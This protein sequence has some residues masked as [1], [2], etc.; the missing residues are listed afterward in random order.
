MKKKL[1]ALMCGLMCATAFT[2]CSNTELAY[3]KM[4]NDMVNTMSTCQVEGKMQADLD[5]DAAQVLLND[6]AKATGGTAFTETALSG[7]KSMMVT[8]D[9]HINM[10]AMAYDM[11]F[12][13]D[14]AGKT[15][16]LGTLY[17][18]I[19]DGIYVTSDTI[20]G[21]YR[22]A[23]A[24][25]N[26]YENR[27][28]MSDAFAKDFKTILAEDEYIELLSLEDLTGTDMDNVLPEGSMT[29]LYD[30]VFTFYQDV[31]DGFETGMVKEANGGYEIKADG[32]EVAQLM[33][34]LLHFIAE[35][36]EQVMDATEAYMMAVLGG[37]EMGNAEETAEAQE[38]MA[39][40][41]AEMRAS[42]GEFV[43]AVEQA[44]VVLEQMLTEEP[45]GMLLDT[46]TYEAF[47]KKTGAGFDSKEVYDVTYQDKTVFRLKTDGKLTK[48]NV[49][50]TMPQDSISVDKLQEELIALEDK[51]NPVTGVS[52]MWGW[53][54][55]NKEATLYAVRAEEPIFGGGAEWTDLVIQ[56]G[57]AY[58]PL[59]VVA[60]TLG[61]KVG[62]ENATKTP[63]VWMDG[64][65]VEMK[66]ILQDNRAFV[67]VRDFEKLG[68][69]VTFTNHGDGNKE[70]LVA[71]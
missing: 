37:M 28:V 26:G 4:C 10:D 21:M 20:W 14:Y 41:F 12:D 44:A 62:W 5:F 68:Y 33:V 15:Y 61:E 19:S 1:A 18:G 27:Y 60:E 52:M 53:E 34:N 39:A 63:Y 7:Q 42:Q 56:N 40:M 46:F 8:Y 11:S 13:V 38:E 24:L 59:R 29:D 58:L 17:Y 69:T 6:V 67:G 31:L 66:G 22:L 35:N 47:V 48:S 64:R 43:M 16:D 49:A 2:G 70:V 65:K 32:R 57:R 9:M 25:T 3:L 30:A 50:V 45:V 23:G 54:P 71:K 55:E 51:Y 36:P